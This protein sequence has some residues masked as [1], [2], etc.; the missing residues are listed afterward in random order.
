MVLLDRARPEPARA[1]P[2]EI[3]LRY[4]ASW[5]AARNPEAE[6]VERGTHRWLDERGLLPDPA[7]HHRY[8]KLSVADYVGWPFPA[9]TGGRFDVI[10]RFFSLWIFY[11]DRLEEADDGQGEALLA[12]TAGAPVLGSDDPYV[13]AW[14]ELG[15]A[16][17]E[18]MS[19]AWSRRH[20]LRFR[21]WADA[22]R[23]ES[24][25]AA[26]LRETGELPRALDHLDA[27]IL[28]I[29]MLPSVDFLD[30]QRG[31]E[32]PEAVVAHPAFAAMERHAAAMVAIQNDLHGQAKD[33]RARWCNLVDCLAAEHGIP[34]DE[35]FQRAVDLHDAHAAGL[36][37]A[38]LRLGDA[39]PEVPALPVWLRD[40]HQMIHGFAVF[41][42]TAPRY[43]T[44]FETAPGMSV[45][46]VLTLVP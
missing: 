2:R 39:F 9:A 18:E 36:R 24:V 11:D 17:A 35:A 33:R 27:R 37:R 15:R 22:V 26:R 40:L 44:T 28:N 6:R 10:A 14:W 25:A 23:T 41:H 7:A 32:L 12:A 38:E 1:T 43:D 4:P 42:A 19:P 29:G 45:R 30:W 46:L 8:R 31:Y 20:A 16:C 34:L 21:E 13:H 5:A 3:R